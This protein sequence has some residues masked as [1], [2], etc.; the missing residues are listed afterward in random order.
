MS[1]SLNSA[2]K[3]FTRREPQPDDAKLIR[4]FVDAEWPCSTAAR[5]IRPQ[6][7]ANHGAELAEH[8]ADIMAHLLDIIARVGDIPGGSVP[9]T[10][11]SRS[12]IF[13]FIA[14]FHAGQR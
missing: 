6:K 2:D 13:Y 14:G 3:R 8:E 4:L 5:R 12:E 7:V 11:P 9:G 10:T 1:L